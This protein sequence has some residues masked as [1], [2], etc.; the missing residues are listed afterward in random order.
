MSCSRVP[1]AATFSAIELH[2]VKTLFLQRQYRNCV[3]SCRELL[4][5]SDDGDIHR[6]P[7]WHVHLRFYLA[8]AHDEL[9]R[10]MHNF[11]PVKIAACREAE[12]LY[13]ASLLTLPSPEVCAKS[14]A[15]ASP[16]D[17]EH[18]PTED[19]PALQQFSSS[20]SLYSAYYGQAMSDFAYSPSVRPARLS[21]QSFYLP[22]SYMLTPARTVTP[23]QED[24]ESHHSFDQIRT[25][26]RVNSLKRDYSSMSLLQPQA[27]PESHDLLR[28]KRVDDLRKQ[29]Q[30]LRTRPRLARIDTGLET[31]STVS[32]QVSTASD[33]KSPELSP[34]SPVDPEDPGLE[35]I[36]SDAT[37][38]SPISP[39]TPAEGTDFNGSAPTTSSPQYHMQQLQEHL[40][41]MRAQIERHIQLLDEEKQ[42]TLTLQGLREA[43]KAPRNL[44][45]PDLNSGRRMQQSHSFWSSMPQDPKI[46]ERQRRIE[47]G[48]K[49]GWMRVRFDPVRYQRLAERAL[50]EL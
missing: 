17:L 24:L 12:Q 23:S 31:T 15:D 20:S 33:H 5:L 30:D 32:Q 7:L 22:P 37:T 10:A 4:A 42:R 34:V 39:G 46:L 1:N 50:Q 44:S 11:S 26:S 21:G 8:L 19:V 35:G 27:H 47:D 28:S 40:D 9:A 14:V 13:H 29:Y 49:R 36:D 16:E 25:P 18:V 41:A 48:R 43:A 6:H 2:L 38:I 3:A 45:E